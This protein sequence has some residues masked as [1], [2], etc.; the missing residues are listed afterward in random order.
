MVTNCFEEDN[1][2]FLPRPSVYCIDRYFSCYTLASGSQASI[3]FMFHRHL[4]QEMDY[5]I[6]SMPVKKVALQE[7][8]LSL[9]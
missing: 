5:N 1:L 7:S 2:F 8:Q 9:I 6:R 4:P 3:N